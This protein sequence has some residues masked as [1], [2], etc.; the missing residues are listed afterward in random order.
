[1]T[2]INMLMNSVPG[3]IVWMNT[4]TL[5]HWRRYQLNLVRVAN[6]WL[7]TF[8]NRKAMSAG[9]L[10]LGFPFFFDEECKRFVTVSSYI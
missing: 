9:E 1:M 8:K 6:V 7:P 2:A 5:E 3:E 4:L 10:Q